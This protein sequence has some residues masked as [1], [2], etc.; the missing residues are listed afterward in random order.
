LEVTV[1]AR[2]TRIDDEFRKAAGQKLAKAAKVFEGTGDIDVEL[3]E[4]HNPRLAGE[5]FRLEVTAPAGAKVIR[6]GASAATPEAALD[7]AVDRFGRQLQRMK[8]RMIDRT[9]HHSDHPAPLPAGESEPEV[10]RLKQFIM[11]PMSVEEAIMEMDVLGHDFYF[12]HNVATDLQSVLY[13]RRDGRLG[14]IEP[15]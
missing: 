4:E 5:R 6:V 15:A 10:V 14:M 11:K 8:E 2:N 3:I 12:F 13:R 1:H 7:S 9:R